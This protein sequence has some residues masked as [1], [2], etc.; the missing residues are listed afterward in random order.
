MLPRALERLLALIVPLDEALLDPLDERVD[1]GGLQLGAE[2]LA[3]LDRSLELLTVDGG[4]AMARFCQAGISQGPAARVFF[5]RV[6]VATESLRR[7]ELIADPR[8]GSQRNRGCLHDEEGRIRRRW[9]TR[10]WIACWPSSAAG[11]ASR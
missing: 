7:S 4:S 11:T 9:A 2:L 8:A 6:P 1:H 3:G 10:R 5:I